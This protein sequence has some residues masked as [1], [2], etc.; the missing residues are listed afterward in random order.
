MN[1]HTRYIQQAKW[2][3]DLRTYLFEKAGL[4]DV[5]CA[6]RTASLVLK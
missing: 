6:H 5:G 1:W 3:R 4:E 2:T